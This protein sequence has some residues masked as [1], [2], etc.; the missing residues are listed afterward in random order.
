MSYLD[1]K[2]TSLWFGG[3]GAGPAITFS[4]SAAIAYV[5]DAKNYTKTFNLKDDRIESI[6]ESPGIKPTKFTYYEKEGLLETVTYPEG[7]SLT[8]KYD[9]SGRRRSDGNLTTLMQNPGDRGNNGSPIDN[10]IF[11]YEPSN[12]QVTSI[13]YPNG[14][15]VNN[16]DPDGN[17]N[18]KTVTASG[19]GMEDIDYHYTFNEF[20]QITSETNMFEM[21]TIYEYYNEAVP[22]GSSKTVSAR[23]L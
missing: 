5:T 23:Q 1:D 6:Q 22:G 17:G 11:V 4:F 12:N 14:L 2:V 3:T 8:Y 15:M 19:E 18:F 21:P 16:T 20:G 9:E 10:T 7:N 13:T